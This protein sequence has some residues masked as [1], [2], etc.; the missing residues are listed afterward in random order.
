MSDLLKL[1]QWLS[2][3][4]PV[5]SFAYSHGVEQ[6]ITTGDV[7][8]AESLLSWLSAILRYG[9]GRTDAILLAE[10]LRGQTELAELADTAEALCA[11]QERWSETIDQ[12]RA[13]LNT[14]NAL[15]AGDL[16]AMAYPV[17]VGRVSRALDLPSADIIGVYLHAF[18]SNIVSCAVRFI[19]L[20]QTEGQRVLDGL[21]EA[22]A[23]VAR[24]A[25]GAGLEDITNAAIGSDLSAMEHERL[26]TRIFRT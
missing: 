20:G 24:E 7:S 1:T 26:H 25:E 6:A 19:P 5:G 8:D 15:F 11:S 16:P 4:F 9:S 17:A 21:H 2:P 3:A 14:T 18:A 23:E 13:F 12:G 22:I 10:A